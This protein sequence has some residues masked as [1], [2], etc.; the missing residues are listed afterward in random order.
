MITN[1]S[2]R[3]IKIHGFCDPHFSSVKEAFANNF[4]SHGDVGAS[5]AATIGGK[6][7]IDIWA[8]YAD[9]ARTRPWE[10]NT[11]ACVY[12][13]TKTMAALCALIL[14]DRGLLDLDAPVARYWLEFAQA[15]KE[16]IPVRYLLSHQSGLAGFEGRIPVEALFDWERMVSLLAAQRPWWEPGTRFGYHALT[17]GYL[18]GEV[19]RRIT[20]RN[21][22]RF[23]HE[24]L[25]GP[26]QADCH[27]GLAQK[28][29][30]RVAEMIP[31]PTM[32][33]GNPLYIGSAL[34]PEMARKSMYPLI[35]QNNPIVVSRSDA[36]RAAVIPSG[37]GYANAH[38]LARIASV[39][40]C[41]EI[42]GKRWFSSDTID[43]AFQEQCHG[44]DL[45][46]GQP[47]RWALGFAMAS[48]G[49][50]IETNPR[51][52]FMGG[53]GGSAVAIDHDA[54]LSLAYVMNNCLGSALEGDDRALSL[55]RSL[56]AVL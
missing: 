51:T 21:V 38:A 42:D 53:G 52:L 22:S 8:G 56:Y 25:A 5:F 50:P 41:D 29:Y 23:F 40:A 47:F 19:I 9:A 37:N 36:W 55:I 43:T 17:Q 10:R 49:I 20:N 39:L 48:Q 28:D 34:M 45:I 11:L 31:P 24:E 7:I 16:K 13:T 2:E 32:Q 4:R 14:V 26:L 35:D 1:V 15:G 27:I 46:L 6:F 54:Q 33:P 3:V 30:S 12:S 18:V 44:I